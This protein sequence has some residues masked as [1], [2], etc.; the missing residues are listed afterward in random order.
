MISQAPRASVPTPTSGSSRGSRTARA[1]C[2]SARISDESKEAEW[3]AEHILELHDGGA[4]WSDIA[5]LC[6]SSR[7]FFSLQQ[8]FAEREIPVGDPGA[9]RVAADARGRRGARLRA[10][11]ERPARERG[12]R[13]DP[14]RPAVPSGLQGPRARGG[15]RQDRRATRSDWRTRRRAR[16]RR[17]CSPRRSSTSTRSRGSPRRG[18][19]GS[20]SSA[21]SSP[22]CASRRA[23]RWASSW[24]RSSGAT[25]ILAELDAPRRTRSRRR[26][27]RNLAAFLD[28]V[29]A[30]E[31]V[32]GELTLRAFLDYVDS[33]ERRTSRSGRR[34]S[35]AAEDSVKVMTIHAAKGLEFDNVFVPGMAK[36]LLPEHADPAQPGRAR[37]VDG[38]RTPRRRR[39]PADATT[40]C[41][42]HFK[43]DL[44]AQEEF[45]ERRTAYVALTRARSGSVRDGRPL[46][47]REHQRE[48]G[49]PVPGGAR[50]VG[51]DG[52]STRSWDPGQRHRRGDNPLLGYRERFVTDWPEPARPDDAT[53]LFAGRL[54]ARGRSTRR[55][56]AAC[57][58]RCS[59]RCDGGARAFEELAAERRHHAGYLLER[60]G[61]DAGDGSAGPSRG[62]PS[63]S[64]A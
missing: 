42:R 24:A 40:A 8:A 22:S 57:S 49:R 54:A 38:L 13:P 20:R 53:T 14:A 44:Q 1:R 11:C 6:R 51:A 29:H 37:E 18:A 32:E 58:R 33:V 43:K 46:V 26:R 17:S 4:R 63:R 45:E 56:P 28:Q 50:R 21:T 15:A 36:G 35:R 25:G 52:A 60:E 48:G 64:A 59:S 23:G 34:C 61:A 19:C 7:L 55:A 47:R 9:R 27:K 16:R 12:A 5:V 41:L 10:R 62:G 2:T 3:I 31:P 39:D 30:F